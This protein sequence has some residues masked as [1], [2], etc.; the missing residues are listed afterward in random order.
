MFAFKFIDKLSLALSVVFLGLVLI[1][2]VSFYALCNE[3]YKK[4]FGY[5]IYCFYRSMPGILYITVKIFA[6]G[7]L[8]GAIHHFFHHKYGLEMLL[9]SILDFLVLLFGILL[10]SLY[11]IFL[12]KAMFWV[13]SLYHFTFIMINLSLYL[14]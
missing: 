12:T 4:K 14:E 2:V 1:L 7:F 5:F 8:R 6:R 10:E 3:T 13:M 11:R 9:L